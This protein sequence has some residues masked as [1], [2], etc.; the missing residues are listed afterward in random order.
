[1]LVYDI[2]PENAQDLA[3]GMLE[4]VAG[5]LS[6]KFEATKPTGLGDVY[7]GFDPYRFDNA[8]MTE[9]IRWVLREHFGLAM[10]P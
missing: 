6:H 3:D 10:Y 4:Q 2:G 9:A 1:M 8:Q 7:W 5:A